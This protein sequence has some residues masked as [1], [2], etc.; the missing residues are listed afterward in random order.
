VWPITQHATYVETS[1][2]T[3]E[4]ILRIPNDGGHVESAVYL[5]RRIEAIALP[6]PSA[7]DVPMF[8]LRARPA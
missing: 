2:S 4:E 3:V 6:A 8:D 1:I 7:V 5:A